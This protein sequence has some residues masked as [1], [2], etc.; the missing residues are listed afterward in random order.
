MKKWEYLFVAF[1]GVG[2]NSV[3]K[4]R[5]KLGEKCFYFTGED[6]EFMLATLDEL[7]SQGW[8]HTGV[9]NSRSLNLFKRELK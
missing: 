5:G 6:Y 3:R 1:T 7:G 8:E 4:G 9:T 2:A